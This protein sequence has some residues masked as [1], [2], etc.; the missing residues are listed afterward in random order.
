MSAVSW[1]LI[2]HE[3]LPMLLKHRN[4]PDTRGFLEHGEEITPEQQQEWWQRIV[5]P[6]IDLYR[7]AKAGG[8]DIGLIR[9]QSLDRDKKTAYVGCDIFSH[10][11]G[12][13]L[14][15]PVFMAACQLAFN[16]GATGE[17]LLWVFSDNE[18]AIRVYGKAGFKKC[19]ERDLSGRKY[20]KYHRILL[21]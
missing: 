9:V 7:I 19:G 16:K 8:D 15:Y 12:C 10:W 17:H 18:R 1:R 4:E 5:R 6:D 11:R 21:A 2:E 14:G 20:L 3:D 13:W